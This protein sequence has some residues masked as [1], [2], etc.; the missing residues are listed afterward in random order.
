MIA[1]FIYIHRSPEAERNYII[2]KEIYD[3]DNASEYFESELE[4]ALE[5]KVKTIVIE[6]AKLGDETS[7][8]IYVGNCLHKTA[9]LS[10]MGCLLVGSVWP[11]RFLAAI[12]L[13]F[14]SVVCAG[15][16]A[17]S[18]QFD[19]CCKY[20]VES[21]TSKL[22][23]LPLQNLTS[24]SPVVLIRRDDSR[25][26]LLHNFIAVLGTSFCAWKVYEWYI[27]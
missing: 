17:V 9:V 6:P 21:D 7:R 10:G 20:Q 25:R 8:W 1:Q 22:Q 24:T 14:C 13:G 19:P 27:K 26:K 3:N 23:T 18:W 11:N 5:A 16:Y 15:V 4:R 12:P 2:I